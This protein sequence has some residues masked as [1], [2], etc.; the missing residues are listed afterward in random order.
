M[1]PT[2]TVL[3]YDL[4][5]RGY[6]ALDIGHLDLEYEWYLMGTNTKV[7]IPHKYV[8]E[9]CGGE[10][11]SDCNDENYISQIVSNIGS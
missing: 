11:V 1:G 3:A 10:V 5:C 2:A 7:N 8:N 4:A 6:Q 9:V